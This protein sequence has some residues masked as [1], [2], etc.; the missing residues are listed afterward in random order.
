MSTIPNMNILLQR[1]EK[2]LE[3]EKYYE[4]LHSLIRPFVKEDMGKTILKIKGNRYYYEETLLI[5]GSHFDERF[6]IEYMEDF[7]ESTF[8]LYCTPLEALPLN[9]TRPLSHQIKV[10]GKDYSFWIVLD[11]RVTNSG[12][13]V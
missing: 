6:K 9:S 13:S 3:K 10:Y 1:S 7:G 2:I 12:S 8:K 5:D 11:D 4:H